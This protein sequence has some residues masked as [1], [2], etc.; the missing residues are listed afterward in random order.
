MCSVAVA[1]L[2]FGK[3]APEVYVVERGV[4]V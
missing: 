3:S 1:V 4:Y 2:I